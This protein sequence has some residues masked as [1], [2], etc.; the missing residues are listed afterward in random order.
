MAVLPTHD[1]NITI[2][3]TLAAAPADGNSF[4]IPI[5]FVPL[6]TNSLDGDVVRSYTNTTDVSDD[7]TAG[8]ISA[9]SSAA[10]IDG[11]SQ[12]PKPPIL[13]LASIDLVGG[14]FVDD[15]YAAAKLVD[16]VFYGVT[17]ESRTD[18]DILLL[19]AVVE[20][21]RRIYVL[22]SDEATWLT[23]GYPAGL[24][25]VEDRE[26]SILAYHDD[27]AQNFDFAW[28]AS[29][30]VFDPDVKSAPW[31]GQVREVAALTA[32]TEGQKTFLLA[33][34]GNV[35]LRFGSTAF[36]V[37]EGTNAA[38]RPISHII[39]MD[40][41]FEN[42]QDDLIALIADLAAD[43][44]KL[45]VD[46]EGQAK[47]L[48]IIEARLQQAVGAGHLSEFQ[49]DNVL[50]TQTHI[51]D[52]QLPYSGRGTLTVGAVKVNLDLNLSTTPLT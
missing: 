8:F 7:L 3:I 24:A 45:T 52:G 13:K 39:T 21:D 46:D 47:G 48:Q 37:M 30:L 17:Q 15:A 27:D 18:A 23:A 26:R 6:A 35:G 28:A 4:G 34:D 9:A 38:G 29:R 33:N 19:S 36:F 44:Q 10:L 16:D 43:G 50:I 5:R 31:I 40:W 14:D 32:L 20:A 42:L 41:I 49:I 11:F 51:D 25:A 22:Q 1:S 2:N 12:I